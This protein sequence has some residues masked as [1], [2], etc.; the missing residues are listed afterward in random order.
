MTTQTRTTKVFSIG[1][2]GRKIDEFCETLQKA[3]VRV[4]LDVR[5]AAWSQR[6]AFRKTALAKAL[7]E[8][9]ITYVHCKVAGNPFRDLSRDPAGWAEC[10][11]RYRAHVR[12][13]PM[14]LDAVAEQVDQGHVALFC[15]ES[16][17]SNCHRG[18]LFDEL[19]RRAGTLAVTDL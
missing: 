12:K 11:R 14:V 5:A 2:Q 15:Y 10:R 18:V 9:G 4:L 3:G 1:Y 8:H 19:R 16:H 17:R 7:N 6:P 13:N